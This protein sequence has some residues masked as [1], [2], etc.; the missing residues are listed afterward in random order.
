[1]AKMK[2]SDYGFDCSFV[3]EGNTDKLI[4]TFGEHM[5]QIHGIEY[6]KEV[7]IGMILNKK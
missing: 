5:N 4:E 1:M 6:Q 2:C 7:L 3:F